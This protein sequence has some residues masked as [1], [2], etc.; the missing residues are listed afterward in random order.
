MEAPEKDVMLSKHSMSLY[1]GKQWKGMVVICSGETLN[2]CLHATLILST[3][4]SL[5][6]P[7]CNDG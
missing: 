5:L 2:L 3:L 4:S 1:L 6:D 7:P